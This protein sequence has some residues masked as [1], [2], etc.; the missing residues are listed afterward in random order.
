MK[1]Y[2]QI[3]VTCLMSALLLLGGCANNTK[4]PV[5]YVNPYVGNIS[6][7]LVPC[8][9]TI[10][11][12]N[13]MMRVYPIRADF[14]SDFMSGLP[15]AVPGHRGGS[16]MSFNPTQA[17]DDQLKPTMTYSY[18]LEH[19]S[20]YS[21]DVYLDEAKIDVKFAPGNQSAIYNFRFNKDGDAKII[22]T[23]R[24]GELKVNADGSVEGYN[25]QGRNDTRLYLYVEADQPV[26]S[27]AKVG[28]GTNSVAVNF[29]KVKEVNIRYGISYI[30]AEQAKNN[31]KRE[32][33]DFNVSVLTEKAR[34]IWNET[35]ANIEVSGGRERD[36]VVFYTSLYR[37]YERM[38]NASEDGRYWSAY[39]QKVHDD[40]GTPFYVDDWVWDTYRAVHPLRVL[41]EPEMELSMAKSYIRMSE[42]DANNWFPTFPGIAGDSRGMNCNHGAAVIADALAK[43]LPL[44][45]TDLENA[46]KGIY[47]AIHEKSLLPFTNQPAMELDAFFH[48][49][50]FYP[51]IPDWE[52]ETYPQVNPG[53]MRQVV[54]VTLGTSYDFWCLA[55][56][57]KALDKAEEYKYC[58]Q[59]SLD[60]R[61]LFNPATGF[62]HPKTADGNFI[63][64][65]D[66]SWSGGQGGRYYYDE[67]NGWVY[68][69]DVQ[70]N[71]SDLVS[72]MGGPAKFA[73]GL[74]DM[75]RTPLGRG[76]Y[77]Y[78]YKFPDHTGNMGQYSAANEPC[79]H[80]PYLYNYAGQPWKTQK[81]TREI[82][83]AYYRDDVMGVPGDED[84]GG[85]T[86]FVVFTQLGFYPVTPGSPTYNIGSP[87]FSKSVI[88]LGNG[89]K[90]E[91]EAKDCSYD[92]KYIQS[93][94]LNGKEWNKP[95][96]SHSDIAGGGRLV[97]QMG[98]KAN[99]KWGS[100]LNNV[101]PSA[102][103]F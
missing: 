78:Y 22:V 7:L 74:D 45:K 16:P 62:F 48:T 11:L 102:E 14:T 80:I 6:H 24:S 35:L 92:N 91:V 34:A 40:E 27:N 3:T 100:D 79:T 42:Q 55:Q 56:I 59:R 49:N 98:P 47:K 25:N 4:A 52:Q 5:D 39:D 64:P 31:L 93:A 97:L 66:Y 81:R 65:V 28:D 83:D 60:Y 96:F 9:P 18:D 99:E 17:A 70:H 8:Y 26:T 10:G 30:S 94:T 86:A 13:N 41:I 73:Q 63:E 95:W 61:N 72:L 57:A 90:F 36:K 43:G 54:P 20:P 67:N 82:I 77:T 38:I 89:K 21:W 58:M 85:M 37:T 29:G 84:G 69:W 76:K 33:N 46:Y 68:R 87:V 88:D 2:R 53:E 50:G 44:D 23:G 51:A 12:P 71:F 32:I 19:I 1:N 101:P 75:F 103:K 15:V